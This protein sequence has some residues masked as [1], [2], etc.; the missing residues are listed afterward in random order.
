MPDAMPTGRLEVLAMRSPR[1]ADAGN[2]SIDVEINFAGL[3][4]VWFTAR[5]D[6]VESHG[7]AIHDAVL[8]GQAGAI[9]AY[10]PP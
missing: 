1:Y 9:A 4:W 7:R 3:G 6:D 2:V 10:E 8:A 5:A